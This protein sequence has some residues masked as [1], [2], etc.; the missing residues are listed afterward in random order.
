MLQLE[1][2]VVERIS[3]DTCFARAITV[4]KVAALAHEV[5]D[6]PSLNVSRV[7]RD[8]EKTTTL[9]RSP[10][11]RVEHVTK[12]QQTNIVNTYDSVEYAPFIAL[13]TSLAV[14]VLAS[15]ESP[16]VFCCCWHNIHK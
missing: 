16:E 3:V 2:L 9:D 12:D 5:G 15:A 6:L 14:Q 1:V 4:D 13:G 10:A 7:F 11:E 8:D